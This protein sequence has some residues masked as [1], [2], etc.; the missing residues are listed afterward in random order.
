MQWGYCE[1]ADAGFWAEPL[2]AVTNGAFL[3][4]ALLGALLLRRRTEPDPAAGGLVAVAFA[5]GLGSFLFHTVPA[6]WSLLADVVPIQLFAFGCF[7]LVMHRLLGQ[8]P[9]RSAAATIA[10]FVA[11]AGLTALLSP[12]LPPGMRGS[13]G[14]AGF[15]LAL[16]ALAALLRRK[17]AASRLLALAGAAFA[18]SL[19]LRSL[20]GPLCAAIPFGTHFLWHLLNGLVVFLLLKLVIEHRPGRVP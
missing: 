9:G 10:F 12:L 11:S 4:A 16:F 17:G 20:D 19:T 18:L 13:A 6:R 2:N 15:V 5:I 14:Y 8:S 7:G 1:R 3:L